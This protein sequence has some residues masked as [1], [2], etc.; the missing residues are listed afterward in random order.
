MSVRVRFP[1]RVLKKAAFQ[2]GSAAFLFY[3]DTKYSSTLHPAI[4]QIDNK[5]KPTP[6]PNNNSIYIWIDEIFILLSRRH[7][8]TER[9]VILIGGP[10]KAG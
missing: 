2:K 3:P 8:Q 1:F 5:L 10:Y 4:F 7:N 9:F 6:H